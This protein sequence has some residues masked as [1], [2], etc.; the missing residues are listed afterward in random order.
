VAPSDFRAEAP[1]GPD[2]GLDARA[3]A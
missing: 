2:S 1:G 3:A